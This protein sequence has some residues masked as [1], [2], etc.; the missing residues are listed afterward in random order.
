MKN[1]KYFCPALTLLTEEHAVDFEGMR[2]QYD[3]IAEAGIDGVVVLGSAGEFYA[4]N[5]ETRLA[6]GENAIRHLRGKMPVYVGTGCTSAGA[7]T[8]FSNK[9]LS[10]GAEGVL[11]VGPYYIQ[12]SREGIFQYFD[13][14][15]S[16][17]KGEMYIYNYPDNTGYDIGYDVILDLL[18][19]HNNI[20]GIKDTV[21]TVSHTEQM[22][23]KVKSRYPDFEIYTGYD[24]NTVSTVMSGGNG[25][26]GAMSNLFPRDCAALIS[27]LNDGDFEMA[28]K[29]KRKIDRMMDIYGVSTPF[30]P[31]MKYAL[32]RMGVNNSGTSLLPAVPLSD[33]QKQK[34]DR[35]LDD[36][37]H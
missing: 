29:W 26:I 35:I 12:A 14:V 6:I 17:V 2:R 16:N 10:L 15:A 25:C 23:V 32:S 18:Q 34:I 19:R 31:A 3:R 37:E 9:M 28:A 22:I 5:H 11:I 27:S 20:A 8:A 7:T 30:M 33:D 4:L 13:N 24:N 21:P 1:A 36:L